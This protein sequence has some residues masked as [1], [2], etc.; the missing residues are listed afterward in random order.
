MRRGSTVLAL[1]VIL[2]SGFLLYCGIYNMHPIQAAKSLA[3]GKNP[4]TDLNVNP[5][6]GPKTDIKAL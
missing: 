3:Q 1:S 6:V 2:I 4:N 5:L